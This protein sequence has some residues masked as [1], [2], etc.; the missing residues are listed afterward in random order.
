MKLNSCTILIMSMSFAFLTIARVSFSAQAGEMDPAD[1]VA[2]E[3]LSKMTLEEK[4]SL[5]R[6]VSTMS[7]NAIPRVGLKDEFT[8]SDGPHTV[9]PDLNRGS[10]APVG[11]ND[12]FSTSL[13]PLSALAA[14]WDPAMA[15]KFGHVLGLEARDRNKDMLLGP[16]VNIMRTPVC[17]RNFEYLG[18]DPKLTSVQAVSVIK[19]IQEMDVAACVKHFA[20][21]NQE[22]N[23]Q[24]MNVEVDERTMREIYLPAFEAAVHE[25]GVLAVM[26]AYNQFRGR[27]CSHSDLLNNQILKKEWGFKGLVVTDWGSLHDTIEGALGGTD[28]E[29]N[30]GG[31]I[32]YFKA[33]LIQAVNEGKVPLPLLDDKAFR[34]L[35]VMAKIHKID[36]APR[37]SGARNT[38]E[39]QKTAREI[40]ANAIVLLKNDKNIL[41]FNPDALKSIMIFGDNGWNKHCGLGWS[42]AGKPPYEISPLDGLKKRLGDKVSIE[43]EP[44]PGSVGVM[45]IPDACIG[46]VD[47]DTKDAGIV[48]KGWKAEYFNNEDLSGTVA[49]E[50]FDRE[51]D[52][53]WLGAEPRKGIK[54]NSFSARWNATVIAPETGKYLLGVKTGGGVRVLVDDQPV[55]EAWQ[56]GRDQL[57]TGSIDLQ[58]DKKY[59]VKIEYSTMKSEN[60]SL[61]F[62]WSPPSKQGGNLS[63]SIAKAKNAS[64]VLIFTGTEHGEGQ[65]KECEGGDRPN[66]KLPEG[67]DV[68]ISALLA[69]LPHA[70]V[71]NLSGAPVEMPWVKAAPTIVQYWYSGQEGGNALASVLVGD[72]NP[73]GKLPCT[74]PRRLEDSPAHALNNYNDKSVN[75]AE[76]VFVGYRWFD[77]KKIEPLFPFGHGLSYTTFSISQPELSAKSIT[78]QE[79]L[80][81]TAKVTN[82]GKRAGAEVVQLYIAAPCSSVPR[83]PKELKGFQKVFLQPGETKTVSFDVS[84]RDLSFW[85]VASHNWKA[86]PGTFDV[87]LGNSS[88]NITGKAAFAL[89]P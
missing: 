55:I 27:F 3:I 37:K 13:P 43:C 15:T 30:A 36:G 20:F 46:T 75:Y 17:G 12:D 74:F 50:G 24:K 88:R 72:V 67:H 40:A 51:V 42:A 47:A 86:V 25:G 7:V 31:Q 69:E 1:K 19:A 89:S 10:F 6:G 44:M 84:A 26:N 66:L 62:G 9:R 5:C 33:P 79:I 76:G 58:A 29:M 82:T 83:P 8:M 80:N 87:L 54:G 28:L 48:I 65:A 64:A 16:G 60:I 68:S 23:R 70:V 11:G 73:S 49:A 22:L 59:Q 2:G 81:V 32:R 85:D 61:S 57:L 34:I 45:Q 14:T 63:Q 53:N 52:F 21:N 18:E 56:G 4:V 77:E 39:I 78:R 35:Y 71:I 38:P 41:P